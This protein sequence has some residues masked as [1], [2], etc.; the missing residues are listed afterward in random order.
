MLWPFET[1]I[2]TAFNIGYTSKE[3][4][5]VGQPFL[6]AYSISW[7]SSERTLRGSIYVNRT[8]ANE[9]L[10]DRLI[11]GRWVQRGVRPNQCHYILTALATRGLYPQ[12]VVEEYN[13]YTF[14]LG[15]GLVH[16]YSKSILACL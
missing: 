3:K 8:A 16:A 15:G 13:H 14:I 5:A 12:L 4:F 2:P 10:A 7:V 6:I 9:W 1:S 11:Y